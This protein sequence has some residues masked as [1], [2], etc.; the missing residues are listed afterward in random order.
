MLFIDLELGSALLTI[1]VATATTKMMLPTN[2]CCNN[3]S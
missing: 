1:K 3:S 2:N